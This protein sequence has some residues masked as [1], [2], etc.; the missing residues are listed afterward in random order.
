[1]NEIFELKPQAYWKRV[2]ARKRLSKKGTA[3]GGV[4]EKV[5]VKRREEGSKMS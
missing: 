5:K 4:E 1:M 2:D 3:Q